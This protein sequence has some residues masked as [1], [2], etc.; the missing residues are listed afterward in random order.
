M[1]ATASV[2]SESASTRSPA[3]T[4]RGVLRP[5]G[6]GRWPAP[7]SM[8]IGGF[9][10]EEELGMARQ[11]K[12]A[13]RERERSRI[14][15]SLLVRSAKSLGRVIG[16]LQRQLDSTAAQ[17]ARGSGSGDAK[18]TDERRPAAKRASSP[19]SR[20][21]RRSSTSPSSPTEPGTRRAASRRAPSTPEGARRRTSSTKRQAAKL[22]GTR[23]R[24]PSTAKKTTGKR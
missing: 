5:D 12:N 22:T 15:E 1:T 14:E 21:R 11:G 2:Q 4:V 20:V 23:Q 24:K 13:L 3:L 7:C 6:E 8:C 18:S 10:Q 19:G 16:S 9:V 17:L